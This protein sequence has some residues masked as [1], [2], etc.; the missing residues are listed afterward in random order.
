MA[1]SKAKTQT[2]SKQIKPS[3]VEVKLKTKE[4]AKDR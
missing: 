2:L 3:A 1:V 4:L